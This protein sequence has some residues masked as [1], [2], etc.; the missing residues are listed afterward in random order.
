VEG[1]EVDG[2]DSLAHLFETD[3]VPTQEA[4]HENLAV[5]PPDGGVLRDP[6]DLEVAR[7]LDRIWPARIGM[8]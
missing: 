8:S 6:P 2:P 1:S 4:A 3:G 5:L 7:V